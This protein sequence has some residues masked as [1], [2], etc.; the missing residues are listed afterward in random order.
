MD[1]KHTVI[2][3]FISLTT[4]IVMI[5]GASYAYFASSVQADDSVPVGAKTPAPTA[6]FLTTSSGEINIDVSNAKMQQ[7]NANDNDAPEDLISRAQLSIYL[8]AAESQKVSTCSYDVIYEWNEN[9]TEYIRTPN[10][11]KEFTIKSKVLGVSN[12][13][14]LPIN[15]P[16]YHLFKIENPPLAET[17]FDELNWQTK[18]VTEG[19]GEDAT[20]KEIRY[21]KLIEGAKVSSLDKDKPTIVNLEFE[22]KFYNANRDQSVQK[23]KNFSGSIKVDNSSISC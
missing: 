1:K 20:T 7:T 12:V 8:S 6:A 11:K 5:I 3:I 2:L 15:D 17:N 14:S 16:N 4:L 9:S 18:T 21:A 22:V 10:V 13:P 23:N 19:I